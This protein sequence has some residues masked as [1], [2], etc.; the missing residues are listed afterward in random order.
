MRVHW[1]QLSLDF[2]GQARMMEFFEH[3]PRVGDFMSTSFYSDARRHM[4]FKDCDR[5]PAF[6]S[7]CHNDPLRSWCAADLATAR[8]CSVTSDSL[9]PRI[10][11]GNNIHHLNSFG[12]RALGAARPRGPPYQRGAPQLK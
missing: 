12:P 7:R 11:E 5:D 3:H 9:I 2:E 4:D 10:A 6:S 8:F 1:S